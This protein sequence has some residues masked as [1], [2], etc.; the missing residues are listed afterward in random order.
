MQTVQ[1][2][3]IWDALQELLY[4]FR[5]ALL[6]D[7]AYQMQLSARRRELHQLAAKT[8]ETLYAG[9]LAEKY[10]DLAFHYEKAEISDKA[11]EYLQKAAD[12]AKAKYQNQ[13]A[14]QLYDR[15]LAHLQDMFGF[16]EVEI[17]TL[18]KKAEILEL[19][20]EWKACQEVCEEALE[21]A[22]QVDDTLRMGQVNRMLGIIFSP[23]RKVRQS[24]EIFRTS[25]RTA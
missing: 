22:K 25:N 5:H 20:G 15:L 3:R 6:R 14:L 13:Q 17:D 16:T 4:I 19:T 21:L 1:R 8:M 9:N 7:A 10:A 2:F 23:H 24:Y 12:A 11:I 18:L